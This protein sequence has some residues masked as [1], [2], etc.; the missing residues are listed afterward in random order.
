L[1]MFK[2]M[3][4]DPN[5]KKGKIIPFPQK[6]GE[7]TQKAK[8]D[9]A[10]KEIGKQETLRL[11]KN[12]APDVSK[13]L[14][15]LLEMPEKLYVAQMQGMTS[16]SSEKEKGIEQLATTLAR[17]GA[18]NKELPMDLPDYGIVLITM[19]SNTYCVFVDRKR[20]VMAFEH[21]SSMHSQGTWSDFSDVLNDSVNAAKNLEERNIS[22]SFVINGKKME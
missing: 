15:Q 11:L 3:K 4:G 7:T 20:K 21:I 14:E 8:D 12:A 2:T 22:F 13:E 1:P 5:E 6:T 16:F 17:G 10:R 18:D 19:G 9:I